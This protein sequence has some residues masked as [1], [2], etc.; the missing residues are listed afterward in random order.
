VRAGAETSAV[1]GTTNAYDTYRLVVAGVDGGDRLESPG[2]RLLT[3]APA[4][5]V[6]QQHS[7]TG[8]HLVVPMDPR[9][10]LA[11]DFPTGTVVSV[12]PRARGM[13]S[14]GE[15]GFKARLGARAISIDASLPFVRVA[16]TPRDPAVFGVVSGVTRNRWYDA[17]ADDRLAVNGLGEGAVLVCDAN[18]PVALGDLLCT[19][20]EPGHAMRQGDDFVRS[21]T[22]GKATMACDFA[23]SQVPDLVPVRAADGS[24]AWSVRPQSDGVPAYDCAVLPSGR[25]GA[26]IACVYMCS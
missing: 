6:T 8:R 3:L 19:S 16:D 5:Q 2:A 24:V 7:F 23:P 14:I 18:G 17:A 26:R 13:D 11:R 12:D 15:G 25:M 21:C 22:L 20:A 9:A 1:C 4:Q 10:D